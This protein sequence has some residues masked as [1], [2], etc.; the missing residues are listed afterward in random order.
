M[1]LPVHRQFAQHDLE[2]SQTS[3]SSLTP[4]SSLPAGTLEKKADTVWVL[5]AENASSRWLLTGP[6]RVLGSKGMRIYTGQL[7]LYTKYQ[8]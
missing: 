6:G 8:T 7:N 5:A 1:S 2:K 3:C 4:Y